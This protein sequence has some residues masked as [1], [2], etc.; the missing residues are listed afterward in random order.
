M[1]LLELEDN[2][3]AGKVTEAAGGEYLPRLLPTPL[4]EVK[5]LQV[6]Q[7]S[8]VGFTLTG[9]AFDWLRPVP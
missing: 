1:T 5:P 2:R 9:A 6:S 4:R 8:G 3:P 7:P